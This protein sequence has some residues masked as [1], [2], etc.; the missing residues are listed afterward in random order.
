MKKIGVLILMIISLSAVMT[1]CRNK[2]EEK[3]EITM[4]HGWGST[5]EDHVAMRQIYEDFE[6]QH[7]HI[8]LNLISM[9]SSTDVVGKVGDLLTVGEIPDIVFTGGDGR[10]SIYKF[11]VNKGYAVDL[12]P[13]IESDVEFAANVSDIKIGR[14]HV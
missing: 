2:Q 1:G 12:M 6:K 14:A 5:E 11:M 3:I 10:E 13:Y 9:P 4:I 8:H 7:P